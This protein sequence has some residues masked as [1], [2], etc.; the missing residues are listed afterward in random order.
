MDF[1]Y[2]II[3]PYCMSTLNELL[4]YCFSSCRK[5]DKCFMFTCGRYL[6]INDVLHG[7]KLNNYL[8]IELYKLV[9]NTF[10]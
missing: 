3:T 4:K 5:S 6:S 8:Y 9:F 2:K 10:T 1:V 7:I